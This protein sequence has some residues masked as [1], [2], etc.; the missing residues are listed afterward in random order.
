MSTGTLLRYIGVYRGRDAGARRT[1]IATYPSHYAKIPK[2][3]LKGCYRRVVGSNKR[4]VFKLG[5]G[6]VMEFHVVIRPGFPPSMEAN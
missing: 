2:G 5:R 3:P 4:A 6:F 1:A